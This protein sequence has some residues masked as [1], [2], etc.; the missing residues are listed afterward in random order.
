M[1]KKKNKF[2]RGVTV[3]ELIVVVF[4][5]TIISS[6]TIFN[7]SSFRSSAS[8]Q[9]LADDIA[10]SIRKAQGYA[11]GVR[12]YN[13]IFSGYGIHFTLK[14]QP[15]T[16]YSGSNKSFVLFANIS[17]PKVYN[18]STMSPSCGDPITENEC[19]EVLN[20]TSSDEI[21]AIKIGLDN[22][23]VIDAGA[24]GMVDIFFNRPNPEPTF[25]YMDGVADIPGSC[26]QSSGISYVV[27]KITNRDGT[28]KAVSIWNNGQIS[29]N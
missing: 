24:E 5:F 9:N 2:N 25:C 26:D 16:P 13:S 7:Y 22:D 1:I 23:E 17:D 3:I 28:S 10:L 19:L 12:G 4:I 27:I 20:I 18:Y 8:I 15:D 14:T 11:I 21:S 6:I 29:V